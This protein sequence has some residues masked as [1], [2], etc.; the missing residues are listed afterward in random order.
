MPVHVG[1]FVEPR[2]EIVEVAES[3]TF[4][5]AK[6]HVGERVVATASLIL[7]ASRSPA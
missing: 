3:L 2:C 4:V 5:E 6:L 7:K 1:D